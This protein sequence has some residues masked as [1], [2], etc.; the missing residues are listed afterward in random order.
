[1]ASS[2]R[3][4]SP[5]PRL[6]ANDVNRHS[7]ETVRR[8]FDPEEVRAYLEVIAR[9]LEAWD[10]RANELREQ[11]AEA[12]ER[13]RNP[14]IDESRLTAALGKQSAQV[15]RKAHD[16]AARIPRTAEER[17]AELVHEAQQKASEAQIRAESE[18][19]ERIAE[20]EL[21]ASAVHQDAEQEATSILE[22][23]R[24]EGELLVSQARDQ[25]RSMLEEAQAARRR[26]LTDLAQRRRAVLLQIEQIRAARDRLTQSVLAVRESVDEIVADLSHADSDARAAAA[27]ANLHAQ[28]EDLIAEPATTSDNGVTIGPVQEVPAVGP[29][30]P[31]AGP[32]SGEPE[33]SAAGSPAPSPER[34]EERLAEVPPSPAVSD[35]PSMAG[36]GEVMFPPGDSGAGEAAGSDEGGPSGAAEAPDVTAAA[37]TVAGPMVAAPTAAVPVTV[38]GDEALAPPAE[39]EESR[40]V[41]ELFARI[42]ASHDAVVDGVVE[43]DGADA[44]PNDATFAVGEEDRVRIEQRAALLDPITSRLARRLKRILQDDQNQLLHRLRASAGPRGDGSEVLPP[45]GEQRARFAQAAQSFLAEATAAGIAYVRELRDT[46]VPDQVDP[47]QVAAAADSLAGAIVTL[48]RR[49]LAG[50]G[51]AISGDLMEATERIGAAYRE[52]RG[53]RIERLVGDHALSAFSAG[54]VSANRDSGLRWVVTAGNGG[55]ADCDDNALAEVVDAGA[56]FPTGHLHPPAHAGCRCLIVPTPV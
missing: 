20:A 37:A 13:A 42:R 50:D 32:E 53:E 29:E 43:G 24:A 30:S 40:S 49:R 55:C 52:W 22:D 21:A 46:A 2:D 4:H 39:N 51:G 36:A 17:A 27:T 54:V 12:E 15:L 19:A 9:E 33:G 8:G 5:P 26:V 56:E 7:F 10:A 16:E 11:L 28:T 18:A 25:G 48:L 23:A 1:M 3:P 45:E 34:D 41:E 38:E 14:V 31:A 47:D 6:S 44:E 35:L